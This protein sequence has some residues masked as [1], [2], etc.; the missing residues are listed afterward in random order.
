MRAAANR[1]DIALFIFLIPS[2]CLQFD[3]GPILS[4]DLP[5]GK[6]WKDFWL[7][8]LKQ[9]ETCRHRLCRYNIRIEKGQVSIEH[10]LNWL[11]TGWHSP[12][13]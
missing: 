12:L 9:P 5:T 8:P 3:P 7:P 1:Q 4:P 2:L 13:T 11:S 6:K 10:V